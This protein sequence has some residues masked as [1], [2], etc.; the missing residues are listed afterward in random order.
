[1]DL[2]DNGNYLFDSLLIATSN[3]YHQLP[4]AESLALENLHNTYHL[5]FKDIWN[6][7]LEIDDRNPIK[8]YFHGDALRYNCVF[9]IYHK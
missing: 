3:L 1:M 4:S 5:D 9:P 2:I 6:V 7:L 8:L